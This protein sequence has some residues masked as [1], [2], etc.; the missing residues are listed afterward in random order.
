MS[1]LACRPVTRGNMWCQFA[2]QGLDANGA[3]LMGATPE[4]IW[5]VPAY[6]PYLQPSF[7][8][9]AVAAAEQKIGYKLPSEY[10]N[11]LKKQNGGYIRFAL[12][13]LV[14]DSIAGIGPHYPSLTAFDWDD[15]QEA[16]SFPLQG[17]VPFDGDGH[18]HLCLDYRKSPGAPAVTHADIECDRE[19]LI[20]DSFADYLAKLQIDVGDD[21]V[22]AGTDIETIKAKLSLL[23]GMAFDPPDIWAYGYPTQRTRLGTKIDPEWVWIS[24][25]T[26]RRGFVR[27]DDPRYAELKDLM[28]GYASRFPELPA[29][30]YILSA[31]D[32]V[33]SKV[34]EA[35]ARSQI[36]ARPLRDYVNAT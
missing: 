13:N 6:L 15:C 31:T 1:V 16:V 25:N 3:F 29:D 32:R 4:T 23:L 21:Y 22:L 9:E 12:P 35:C 7:T 18:W 20:A 33:R 19:F 34:I 8:D 17:L 24:P 30:G 5:Q 28:P 14:H 2:N 11:L 10:L 27:S 36:V 26:V